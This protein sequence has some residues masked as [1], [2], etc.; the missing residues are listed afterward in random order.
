[1]SV[2]KSDSGGEHKVPKMQKQKTEGKKKRK[3]EK[4][5]RAARYLTQPT[6]HRFIQRP[7]KPLPRLC[8]QRVLVQDHQMRTYDLRSHRVTF[9]RHGGRA[10]RLLDFLSRW[11]VSDRSRQG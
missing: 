5:V 2:R 4:G 10:E 7:P 6:Y 1:M 9:V 11:G 8:H 3:K